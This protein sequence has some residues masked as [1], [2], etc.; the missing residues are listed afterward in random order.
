MI[1]E[2]DESVGRVVKAL[3]DRGILNNT[4]I[5][6]MADNGGET[7]GIHSNHA[8]NWPL[9]G[10]GHNINTQR[11]PEARHHTCRMGCL[12]TGAGEQETR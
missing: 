6:F 4:I 12:L 8:S 7:L 1:R 3:Q 2:L 10:V 9:R 11:A 5:V